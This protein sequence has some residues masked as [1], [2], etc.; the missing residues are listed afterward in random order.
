MDI[1]RSPDGTDAV[2]DALG[3]HTDNLGFLY[4]P[5]SLSMN[6]HRLPPSVA[7]SENQHY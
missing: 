4:V 7:V 5:E 3:I 6:C 1:L 2:E